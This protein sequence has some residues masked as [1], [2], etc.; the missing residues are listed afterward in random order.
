MDCEVHVANDFS[1]VANQSQ[2]VWTS[3]ILAAQRVLGIM[4]LCIWQL[5]L[6][7]QSPVTTVGV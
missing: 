5:A 6:L 4:H 2:L 1:K 7:A 3:S